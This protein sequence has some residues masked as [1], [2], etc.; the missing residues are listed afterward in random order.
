VR[1]SS[2]FV[3]PG[4]RWIS[5][6][7]M[8]ASSHLIA[9]TSP[10][11]MPVWYIATSTLDPGPTPSSANSTKHLGAP[12]RITE[13]HCAHLLLFQN[14]AKGIGVDAGAELLR[15]FDFID[16]VHTSRRFQRPVPNWARFIGESQLCRA[17]RW[18]A[19]PIFLSGLCVQRSGVSLVSLSGAT[20]PTSSRL[21]TRE[22]K[23]Q[24]VD[25][26]VNGDVRV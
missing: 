1:A 9:S 15:E 21:T 4:S 16:T 11:L 2:C 14:S 26:R 17:S 23:I 7:G 8:S 10:I 22:P 18:S 24:I 13:P 6:S 3:V 20:V 5:R 12:L 25:L 19:A